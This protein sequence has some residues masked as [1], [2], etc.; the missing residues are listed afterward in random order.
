MKIIAVQGLRAILDDG[1]DVDIT[2]ISGS[3]RKGC[4]VEEE[5]GKWKVTRN[6]VD[7]DCPGGKCP[8]R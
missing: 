2:K 4:H 3:P 7:R 6:N 5:D 1:T 8:I